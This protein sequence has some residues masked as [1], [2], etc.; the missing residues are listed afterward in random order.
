M[1]IVKT[2]KG[3]A[4]PDGATYHVEGHRC[5]FYK[6]S[7][8]RDVNDVYGEEF[9]HYEIRFSSPR[10]QQWVR[11]SSLPDGATKLPYD[12]Q[13]TTTTERLK[14]ERAAVAKKEQEVYDLWKAEY[15]K[16]YPQRLEEMVKAVVSGGR[17]ENGV[18]D[19]A[20]DLIKQIDKELRNATI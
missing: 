16:T 15:D 19:Y 14:I 4:V 3:R 20:V 10:Y 11:V 17:I 12:Y 13:V 8:H 5:G 9:Y 18:V 7:T 1:A 2:F 6:M